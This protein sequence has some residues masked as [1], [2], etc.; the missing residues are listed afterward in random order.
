MQATITVNTTKPDSGDLVTLTGVRVE[1]SG[2]EISGTEKQ[3]AW[4]SE[5]LAGAIASMARQVIT[6]GNGN[7]IF[8]AAELAAKVEK[9]QGQVAATLAGFGR[10]DARSI[11]DKRSRGAAMIVR[12]LA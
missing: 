9:V 11:I 1:I 10:A 3:V 4:A 7:D 2:V 6:H 12:A 8:R 5:I